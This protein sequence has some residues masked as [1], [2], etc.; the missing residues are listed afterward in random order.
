MA[1]AQSQDIRIS[2]D[3]HVSEPP[4]LW[5]KELPQQYKERAPRFPR[6]RIGSALHAREGGWD[7]EARIAD[8]AMDGIV[9]EVLYPTLAKGIYEQC[10]D[11][12]EV[13]QFSDRV[14]NDWMIDFCSKA[15]DRLWGQAHI[16]LWDIDYAVAELARCKEAGL[17]GATIWSAPPE[18]LSFASDHYERFWATAQ[19]LE[20]PIST[21]INSGF[22]MYA[23]RDE[24]NGLAAAARR[25]FGHKAVAAQMLTELIISGVFERYPGLKI[26]MAEYEIGWIPFFLEDLDRKFANNR[27]RYIPMEPS[28]YFNRQVFATFEQDGVGGFLLQRWGSDN[29]LFANDYPHS[30]GIWPHSDDVIELTMGH[31][32]AETKAKVL[33]GNTAR[34]YGRPIPSAMPRQP[35]P[36]M[37]ETWKRPW[38][39]RVGDYTYDKPVM[40]L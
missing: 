15:P 29:F 7:P 39:K 8:M 1:A 12:P 13:A 31:L 16:G 5:E 2:A 28:A 21:H 38:L 20:M 14:Y 19:D 9:A 17:A 32:D 33:H 35:A 23:A 26:V 40:G 36:D 6:V 22:G 11:D 25:A 30:G 34:V 27:S 10:G 24:E 18:G 4:D 3:S 37:G